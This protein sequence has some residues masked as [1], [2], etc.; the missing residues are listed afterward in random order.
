MWW[1]DRRAVETPTASRRWFSNLAIIA[2]L[3]GVY[4]GAGKLGLALAFVHPSATAVWPPTGIALAA[5]LALG[6][7]V[8]PGIFL[9]A[10]LVNV[11]TEGSVVTS[12]GIALGNTLEGLAGAYLVNRFAN[13]RYPFDRPQDIFKFLV[14][15][16]MLSTTVSATF[17]VTSLSLGGFASWA[18][19]GAIWFT[20]WLGDAV[21]ALVVASVLLLWSDHPRPRWS[22][23]QILEAALLLLS[24]VLVGLVVFGGWFPSDTKTYPLAFLSIPSLIWAA[25]RF[26]QRETATATLMLAGIAIWGTLRGFGPFAWASPNESL[27]LLQAFI[28]VVAVM[29]IALAAVVSERRSVEAQLV[30]LVAHD[31]LTGLL[32]RRRFQ[33]ELSL[34][35]AQAGRYGT[36]GALLFLD[37]DEFK[38]VNDGL[39]HRTGDDLLIS[40][41]RLLRGRLRESDLLARLGGDEFAILLPHT[42]GDQAQVV[43]GRLLE[44]IRH[45]SIV[46]K[47]RPIGITAS[48]GIAL[49]PEYGTTVEELLAHAD[50]ALYQAKEKGR[51]R[52]GMSVPDRD[53]HAQMESR[54]KVERRIRQA[55]EEDLFLLYAQPILDLR[56][57]RIAQYELL[58][59]MVGDGGT[60]LLPSDFLY[61][62]ERFGLIHDIDRWVAQQAIHL[63][64]RHGQ[65]FPEL[66]LSVNLSGKAFLDGELLPMIQREL[67]RTSTNP[68]NLTL[69]ITESAA[70]ADTNQ[71]QRFAD[72][73]RRL[74][75]RFAL[76]DFGVGFSSLS[77]LKHLPVDYLKIDGSFIRDLPNNPVDQHLVKAVVEVA[78]GL[79]KETIAEFVGD[80]ETVQLLREYG[81]DFAQG[82]YIGE[83]RAVP[84][85]FTERISPPLGRRTFLPAS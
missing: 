61:I 80:E 66:R 50:R 19:Y 64:A 55:F 26:G 22:R 79:H 81:V 3:A 21:G 28:G 25:F 7:R 31:P 73:L 62:A 69:E 52:F 42:D 84:E 33:E 82:F 13:G 29:A 30:H 23:G 20:W 65:A 38:S 45:H 78:R 12:M 10:F 75:C 46:A 14:L 72:A 4:F 71:A 47:E 6:Y 44:A 76:D 17:G 56:S 63:L 40:L 59:R 54:L 8:W 68:A 18:D 5:L 24:I 36:R 1:P 37:L 77:H 9:G 34:Q 41:S 32:S 16:G 83:P 85:I 35:L 43:A 58:L 67:D 53:W 2:P 39:G 27:L 74:G 51:N 70:I 15:A 48:I 49:F 57:H 60:I 11:T